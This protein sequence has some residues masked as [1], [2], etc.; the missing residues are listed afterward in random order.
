VVWLMIPAGDATENAFQT[1]VP[2]LE[3]GD[4]MVDGGNANFR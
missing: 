4:V 1:L 3:D 2:L